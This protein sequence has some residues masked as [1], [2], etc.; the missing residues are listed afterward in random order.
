MHS[1]HSPHIGLLSDVAKLKVLHRTKAT[2]HCN[3]YRSSYSH[4]TP[5]KVHIPWKLGPQ[6]FH[7]TD[8]LLLH[9]LPMQTWHG[10]QR[11]W[12]ILLPSRETCCIYDCLLVGIQP[13]PLIWR[14]PS[15]WEKVAITSRKLAV[16]SAFSLRRFE[17]P[18]LQHNR[19]LSP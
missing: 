16:K 13:P 11:I 14:D 2:K 6:M 9:K 3:Y 19:C 5:Q 1:G 4:T 17:S 7:S 15:C 10:A 18:C 12:S 8:P